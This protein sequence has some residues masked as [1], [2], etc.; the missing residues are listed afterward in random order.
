[1]TP[2]CFCTISTPCIIFP[3]LSFGAC[4][5]VC[6]CTE[7]CDS[8]NILRLFYFECFGIN[9]WVNNSLPRVLNN[10]SV[11]LPHNFYTHH[12]L[13]ISSI[14]LVNLCKCYSRMAGFCYCSDIQSIYTLAPEIALTAVDR[15]CI[16]L[17]F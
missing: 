13:A 11:H 8:V 9:K 15:S 17:L 5:L 16:F 6:G 3:T 12:L 4:Q 14:F 10:K 7:C 2:H 1:M